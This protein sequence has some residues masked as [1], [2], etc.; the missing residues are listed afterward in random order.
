MSDE[1]KE[2]KVEQVSYGAGKKTFEGSLTYIRS[3]EKNTELTRISGIVLAAIGLLLAL[4][5]ETPQKEAI[6][7]AQGFDVPAIGSH[8]GDP[9]KGEYNRGQDAKNIDFKNKNQALSQIK[10]TGPKLFV[11]N[12]KIN[13]PPG[14]EV[15]A[16]LINGASNGL[17]KAK[18][19]DDVVAAGELFLNAGTIIIGQGSSTEDRLFIRFDKAVLEDGSVSKLQAEAADFSDRTMGLKGSKI[20]SHAIKMAARAGLNFLAGASIALEDTHGEQGAVV[21]KPTVRNA[22]L[23]G[24]AKAAIEEANDIASQYKSA[25]PILA[26][27]AGTEIIIIFTDEG[28]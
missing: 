27:K 21:A 10:L 23:Q 22:A 13:I 8:Q 25:P 26:V 7:D 12:L 16:K 14:I 4:M 28:V 19:L 2:S 1:V 6:K 20:S 3:S 9:T 11:R 24:T 5:R 18:L 15:R 17:V